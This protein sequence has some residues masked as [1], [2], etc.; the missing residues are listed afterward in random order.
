MK[1]SAESAKETILLVDDTS[2]N[3]LALKS[4]LEKPGRCLLQASSGEAAL[5][6]AMN[7]TLDLIILDVQMPEMDGFEVAQ[8]LKSNKKTQNIPIIFASAEKKEH[9]SMMKGFEEGAVDYLSKPLDPEITKAKV[10]VLLKIQLQKKELLEKNALLGK[11]ALLINNS[12]DIIGIIDCKTLLIDEINEACANILGYPLN[13]IK[14]TSL[15]FFLDNEDRERV[16]QLSRRREPRLSFETRVHCKDRTV[17]CLAWNI[18]VKDDKWYVNAR[19]ITEI[20]GAERVRNYVATVV[21][22]S[23]DAI[24]IHDFEGNIISWNEGAEKIYGYSEGEALRMKVWSIVPDY[25]RPDASDVYAMIF[26]GTKIELRETRRIT[27]HGNFVDVLFSAAVIHDP[28]SHQRSV[29]ITERDVTRQKE[30]DEQIRQLNRDLQRNVAQLEEINKE[31]EAFSYSVSHDLRAPL[32]SIG[33]HAKILE[34]DYAELLDQDGKELLNIID[35]NVKRMNRLID[36]LLSLSKIGKKGLSK[37]TI[38]TNAQVRQVVNEI[39]DVSGNNVDIR[40]HELSRAF[41]DPSLLYQVWTNLISNA[42]KYSGKKTAPTVEVGS[43]NEDGATVYYVKD[44]GAGFD[45]KYADR[46]FGAFQRLHDQNEF[47]GTGIGLAIVKRVINKHGGQVWA[48]AKRNE[49][50]TFYFSLP[51]T[52]DEE[53]H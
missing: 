41:G 19:D 32:R 7:K 2:A 52:A 14:G 9:H 53:G 44:N 43:M 13:E 11:S 6:I 34:E 45:M 37:S 10:S 22:Q 26:S 38:D 4:L 5:K 36:D 29:A 12:V 16:Q 35:G 1:K 3:L 8:F 31:L 40:V 25:L 23:G 30:L 21:K 49:G 27:K 28:A 20:K 42:V 24:Y 17:K 47:E 18:T 50:A 51:Q 15:M 39:A 48:T 46:L 33:G